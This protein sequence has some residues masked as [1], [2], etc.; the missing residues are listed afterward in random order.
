MGLFRSANAT[1]LHLAL[2]AYPIAIRI[3]WVIMETC[4]FRPE[5]GLHALRHTFLTEAC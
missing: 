5:A 2:S 4:S 3:T 1:K